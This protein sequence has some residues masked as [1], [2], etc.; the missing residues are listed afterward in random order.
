VKLDLS[1]REKE[2]E[3][4]CFPCEALF[5]I[6]NWQTGYL[7]HWRF[8]SAKTQFYSAFQT[9]ILQRFQSYQIP[10]IKLKKTVQKEAVCH[11]FEKVNTGGV[12]LNAFELLTAI[13]ATDDF[14][15][16]DDWYGNA[17]RKAIGA[18][19][20]MSQK[21]VLRGVQNTDFLQAVTLIQTYRR[22]REDIVAGKSQDEMKGV[23]CKRSAV[24]ELPRT[25][26]QALRDH[27]LVGFLRAAKFLTLE[28]I[29][30]D[31]DLPYQTQLVPLAA[32]LAEL[33]DGWEEI[34]TK[35]KVRQW[36]W[37]GVLGELYG[38]AVESRHARDLPEVLE[39][40][41]GG[42]PPTTVRD[43]N[44]NPDRVLTLRTRNSAAYKGIYALLM[45]SGG[46]EFLTDQPM[47]FATYEEE[48]IDIHHIFPKAWCQAQAH[49]DAK[50]MDCIVNKTAISARTNRIIGGAPPA[51]YLA[52]L[53]RRG[54]IAPETLDRI[55][56][57]HLISTE[58]LRVDDFETF[59][60]ARR[61]ALIE[62]IRTAM[63]KAAVASVEDWIEPAGEPIEGEDDSDD[64][65]EVLEAA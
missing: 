21:K 19:Q 10:V 65:A 48:K 5:D 42:P 41:R 27:V 57:T 49:I 60:E 46:R 31:R 20:V 14:R 29:F 53:E 8:D 7:Q 61:K 39:W 28:H 6:F 16:R 4:D 63:G 47:S 43:A 11:V 12:V 45:Q 25:D 52:A 24:L 56:A 17:G 22:R 3:N 15:L 40:I 18:H 58:A 2:F 9:E 59:F 1:T 35:G 36:Y 50:R 62:L 51:K 23:S 55:L 44:F 38:G 26:Y 30:L 13:Y 34:G 37:C 32:I 64:E 54:G 33:G